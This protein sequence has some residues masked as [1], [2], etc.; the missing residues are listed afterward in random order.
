MLPN[1]LE[2]FINIFNLFRYTGSENN[3]CQQNI[4][5]NTLHTLLASLFSLNYLMDQSMSP[6]ASV[7]NID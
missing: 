4:L 1:D 5:K 2:Y 6:V 7:N 3:F